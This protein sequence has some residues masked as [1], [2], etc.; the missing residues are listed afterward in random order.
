MAK[1]ILHKLMEAKQNTTKGKIDQGAKTRKKFLELNENK[2]NI[3]KTMRHRESSS[4]RKH[5]M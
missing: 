1:E 5:C 4:L 3:S 2:N